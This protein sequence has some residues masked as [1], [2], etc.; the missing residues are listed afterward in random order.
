MINI[1]INLILDL[2]KLKHREVYNLHRLRGREMW[3]QIVNPG[4]IP[5][6]SP[7]PFYYIMISL[8]HFKTYKTVKVPLMMT[9]KSK[10]V[11]INFIFILLSHLSAGYVTGG[12]LELGEIRDKNWERWEEKLRCWSIAHL[13]GGKRTRDQ[14]S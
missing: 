8:T 5:T 11:A 12:I 14:S 7:I 4:Q 1:T 10:R 2:R 6:F 9:W 3:N 13:C